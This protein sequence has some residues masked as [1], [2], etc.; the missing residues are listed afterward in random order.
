MTL[1]QAMGLQNNEKP[2]PPP[3]P[4]DADFVKLGTREPDWDLDPSDPA[5]DYVERYIQAT[6]RYA[7]ERP[8][9]HAQAS[10]VEGGRT[11]VDTRDSSENGCK[12]TGAVR[13]TFAADVEHDRLDLA[14]PARGAPLADWPDG[15]N[16]GGMPG[17][18]SEGG[19]T[20]RQV[21]VADPKGAEEPRA[22]ATP[23]AVLRAREL[24]GDQRRRVAREDDAHVV[25]RRAGG[26]RDGDLRRVVRVPAGDPRRRTIG[27]PCLRIKCP[28]ST[29]WDHL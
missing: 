7:A 5:R 21:G 27:R 1:A 10:R 3:P 9:V 22:R 17:A 29:R 12:G 15:S 11:L 13:D 20:D 18:G 2:D 19:A 16:P 25:P 6:R 28:A 24:P 4:T 26:G 8:C 23:C 14:D